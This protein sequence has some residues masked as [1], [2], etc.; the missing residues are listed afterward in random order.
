MLKKW[1]M[2]WI[3]PARDKKQWR[4]S[5][6]QGTELITK[7]AITK[8]VTLQNSELHLTSFKITNHQ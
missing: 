5:C 8:A 3:N 4:G 7:M 2:G 6:E 1:D